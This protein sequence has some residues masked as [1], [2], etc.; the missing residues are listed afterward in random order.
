MIPVSFSSAAV[1]NAAIRADYVA[2]TAG[3][4]GQSPGRSAGLDA[5]RTDRVDLSAQALRLGEFR[6]DT[7]GSDDGSIRQDLVQRVRESIARGEYES[8]VKIAIAADALAR[9]AIDVRG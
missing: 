9:R 8:P 2:R 6:A 3:T 7:L 5:R 4:D 1:G